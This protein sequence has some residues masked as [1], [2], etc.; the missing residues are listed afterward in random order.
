M[1]PANRQIRYREARQAIRKARKLVGM[2]QGT[3]GLEGLAL[4]KKTLKDLTKETTYELL[5]ISK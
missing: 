2:V 1:P 4:D 5:G 3:M